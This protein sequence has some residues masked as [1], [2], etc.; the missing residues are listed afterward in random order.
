MVTKKE[1]QKLDTIPEIKKVLE[2]DIDCRYTINEEVKINFGIYKNKIVKILGVSMNEN[3]IYY[4]VSL[5]IQKTNKAYTSIELE[6]EESKLEPK[7][8]FKIPFIR[9]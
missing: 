4:K 3:K 2:Q 6:F 9:R 7:P 8:Q 1:K 5:I